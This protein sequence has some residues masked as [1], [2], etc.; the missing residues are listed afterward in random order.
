VTAS[1]RPAL[2]VAFER[3]RRLLWNLCYRM[4]GVAAD[5]DD[6]VQETFVRALS[7]PPADVDADL[8]S[9]LTRVAVNLARDHLRA[10]RRRA[11]PGPWLP[12][13]IET[14]EAEGW[15]AYEPQS[16]E[17]RYD[18]LESC[19]FAFLLALEAL[20]PQQRAVLLLREVF[21]YA[22][23]DTAAAL[24]L[25]ET[26]VKVTHLRARRRMAAYDRARRPPTRALQDTTRRTL[27]RFLDALIRG[28]GYDVEAL[29]AAGLR[30]LND[31]GGEFHA[32]RKPV[33]GCA[34]VGRFLRRLRELAGES[35]RVD[36]RLVNGLPAL[37]VEFG[38]RKAGYPPH[39][40]IHR[41]VDAEGQ[42]H[43][44]FS[45]LATRKLRAVRL[46]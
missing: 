1:T 18:L 17:G 21:D 20:T 16:T 11:W 24:D 22:V 35:P 27:E 6:L 29:L 3:H 9:W 8:G 23:S 15:P 28:D 33:N 40:V 38:P 30:A 12:A 4:T 31:S 34:C 2:D 10:R 32:A 44:V 46:G 13:P 19:T 36:I 14:P 26:N 7:R 39:A 37:V 43:G 41:D 45:V 25:R 5:A 42:V